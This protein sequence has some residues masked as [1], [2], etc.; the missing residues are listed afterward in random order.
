MQHNDATARSDS[1]SE[2]L[3]AGSE[4][5]TMSTKRS[6]KAGSPIC[7]VVAD[8][9]PGGAQMTKP[10]SQP[11]SEFRDDTALAVARDAIVARRK[12]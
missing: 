1:G 4:D 10:V 3:L 9:A 5:S 2:R 7:G 12:T 6:W 11:P 8:V